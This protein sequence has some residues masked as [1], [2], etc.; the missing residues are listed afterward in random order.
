MK[1][2]TRLV[3]LSVSALVLAGCSHTPER[4]MEATSAPHAWQQPL[5]EGADTQVKKA[6]DDP[7]VAAN[8]TQQWWQSLDDADL[9]RL[10]QE[11]LDAAPDVLTAQ[12]AIREARAY[13]IQAEGA[14]LPSLDLTGSAGQTHQNNQTTDVFSLVLDAAWEPDVFGQGHSQLSA[15]EASENAAKADYADTLVSLSAEVATYYVALRGYQAQLEVTQASLQSWLETVELTQLQEQAGLV[16]QLDVEQA[17]RSFEQT[18]ASL[19]TLQQNIIETQYK[20]ALLMGRQPD[21]LPEFLKQGT[22]LPVSPQSVFLP[23]P[24]EVLRERPDV[25]AAE[26]RVLSAMANTDA[27]AANRLPSFRLSG[28][29]GVSSAELSDLF[30]P[31]SILRS[32]SAS[33]VQPLFDGDQL[34]AQE[35]IQRE[36]EAQALVSY[37]QVVLNALIETE[38]ALAG[39]YH[40]RATLEALALALQASQREEQL[41]LIQYQAGESSFSDVLDA[42]RT[43]LTLRQ[44]NVEAQ[45]TELAQLITL[46]KA[47]AGGWAWVKTEH[48]LNS[49]SQKD[50]NNE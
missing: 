17:K 15:A 13:R 12:S 33:V 39:L 14:L 21:A 18:R 16:T 8:M 26:Q 31:D 3:A 41:A 46:S 9:N 27:A 45:A 5:P 20:I 34:E 43:R 30:S 25:K 32:L 22:P 44:Q 29:L 50:N 35:T 6:P 28:S 19:P 47:T 1:T 48:T 49:A 38:N 11:T 7:A 4:K 42:Q 24:A 37:R 23:M 10:I 36:Q 2:S 40:S